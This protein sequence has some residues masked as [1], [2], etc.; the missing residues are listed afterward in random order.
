MRNLEQFY[1]QY[2]RFQAVR[3]AAK[4]NL[5][6]QIELYNEGLIQ[7][8]IVLQAVVDWGNSVSSE[9]NALV[10]YNTELARLERETGT[11]LEAHGVAFFEERYGSIGPLGRVANDQCYPETLNP[12]PDVQRYEST[13]LPSEEF[14]DLTD[15]LE[16]KDEQESGEGNE[17]NEES[18][19]AQGQNLN[20]KQTSK[21]D[22]RQ[23]LRA[24]ATQRLHDLFR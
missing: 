22:A 21:K 7:F 3:K 1:E 2:K 17:L 4:V 12:T 18:G 24:R 9:A 13:E 5:D 14:F 11:I 20:L 6:Q 10:Q 16:A 15:P 8:I 19:R 23:S